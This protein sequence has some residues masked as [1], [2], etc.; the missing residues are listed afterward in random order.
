MVPYAK[1]T[2]HWRKGINCQTPA[3]SHDSRRIN[4]ADKAM[5]RQAATSP[6]SWMAKILSLVSDLF[7]VPLRRVPCAIALILLIK[8]RDGQMVGL[9]MLYGHRLNE[10]HCSSRHSRILMN[11]ALIRPRHDS[12]RIECSMC[13]T[14]VR[15]F[16]CTAQ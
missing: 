2:P 10:P 11:C 1:A 3:T 7:N 13:R 16:S 14:V 5:A 8:H 6:I 15:A 9:V 12:C 4:T